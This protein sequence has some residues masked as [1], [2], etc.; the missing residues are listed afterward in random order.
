MKT[1]FRFLYFLAYLL[2]PTQLIFSQ[3]ISNREFRKTTWFTFNRDSLFYK[4][5]TI[6]LIKYSNPIKENGNVFFYQESEFFND[7]ESVILRFMTKRYLNFSVKKFHM[8]SVYLMKWKL[9]N[10]D[11]TLTLKNKIGIEYIFKV[12]L[13]KNLD[14]ENNGQIFRTKEILMIKK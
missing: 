2:L 4:S 10:K 13:I 12:L 5:D 14:F 3:S 7:T 8:S 1:R 9:N 11:S 6:R